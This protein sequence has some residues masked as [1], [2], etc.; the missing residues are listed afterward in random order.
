MGSLC[1]HRCE[2][3][4]LP[5]AWEL[6]RA[7]DETKVREGLPKAEQGDWWGFLSLFPLQTP[8]T[9]DKGWGVLPITFNEYL[10]CARPVLRDPHE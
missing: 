8:F 4:S 5:P 2:H 10:L 1:V 9:S 7:Q 6:R 3:R